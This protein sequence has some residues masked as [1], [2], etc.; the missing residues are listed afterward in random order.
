MLRKLLL[1]NCLAAAAMLL[2]GF[3]LRLQAE[4]KNLRADHAILQQERQEL[5]EQVASL[6]QENRNLYLQLDI[7]KRQL[8]ESQEAVSQ[9]AIE[10]SETQ[11]SLQECQT[12]RD[13]WASCAQ[14]LMHREQLAHLKVKYPL[15]TPA[16]LKEF[17]LQDDTSELPYISKES[18][19]SIARGE[20]AEPY[21]EMR[22]C[23]HFAETLEQR[24]EAAGISAWFVETIDTPGYPPG[25]HH[26]M[27]AVP[28][29]EGIYFIEPQGAWE[30][31]WQVLP[32]CFGEGL[33]GEFVLFNERP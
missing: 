3:Q 5:V 15:P 29:T 23:H 24:L 30:L 17:L 22:I 2:M 11:D 26:A 12:Q 20:L 18:L 9:L 33:S 27:V 25:T 14:S 19:C 31:R 16:E 13:E 1:V 28:T 6:S 21:S 10:L 8:A 32:F 7:A 4:L